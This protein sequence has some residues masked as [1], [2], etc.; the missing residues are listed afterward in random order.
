MTEPTRTTWW[1]FWKRAPTPGPAAKTIAAVAANSD[2]SVVAAEPS[3]PPRADFSAGRKENIEASPQLTGLSRCF[4]YRKSWFLQA[5]DYSVARSPIPVSIRRDKY[6]DLYV[7]FHFKTKSE[8]EHVWSIVTAFGKYQPYREKWIVEDAK[9]LSET[10]EISRDDLITYLE[11]HRA[12]RL[13]RDGPT[14]K[15]IVEHERAC[16]LLPQLAVYSS[17]DWNFQI[18]YLSTWKVVFENRQT[19]DWNAVVAIADSGNNGSIGMMVNARDGA[20]LAHASVVSIGSQGGKRKLFQ[21]PAEFLRRTLDEDAAAFP[22]YKEVA[23]S[24]LTIGKSP[25]VRR[26]YS[27]DGKTG[28][29]QEMSIFIFCPTSAYDLVFEAP[30]ADWARHEP[31]FQRIVDSFRWL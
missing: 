15:S 22:G 11:A 23:S 10:I 30:A 3:A 18:A 9:L 13:K 26:I 17:K 24:E 8:E 2:E 28:R 16:L 12:E 20:L 4:H 5:Y 19:G 14:S 31:T 25:A 27:Y 1:Q 6:N 7:A 29:R 21:S